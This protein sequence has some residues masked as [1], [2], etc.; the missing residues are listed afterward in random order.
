MGELLCADIRQR[1]DHFL[2]RHGI[3]LGQIPHGS[4]QFPV[5]TAELTDNDLRDLRVGLCDLHRILQS[6]FIIPH[7]SASS[8]LPG[9][10]LVDPVPALRAG[11]VCC[12]NRQGAV[13]LR[14]FFQ[15]VVPLRL[16]S[17]K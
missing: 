12:V 10:R 14:I 17:W 5:G 16:A 6:L 2:I 1:P 13:G 3:P 4:G 7:R 8:F 15:C 11:A 9:P